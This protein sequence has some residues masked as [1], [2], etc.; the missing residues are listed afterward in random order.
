[1]PDAGPRDRRADQRQSSDSALAR[2]PRTASRVPRAAGGVQRRS[3]GTVP[4]LPERHL[5]RLRR[6][7]R[8][9]GARA[10]TSGVPPTSSPFRRSWRG[11]TC[12]S[13]TRSSTRRSTRRAATCRAPVTTSR[14]TR[15]SD[16][17]HG[18]LVRGARVLATLAPVRR[19]DR[20]VP[21]IAA[22]RRRRRLRARVLHSDVD[23]GP[24]VPLPRQLQHGGRPVRSSA[25]EPLRRA[26]RVRHL[27]RRRG[28]AR[29]RVHR[30][31]ASTSTTRS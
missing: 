22:S 6:P 7:R 3:H 30:R 11:A 15:S 13:R 12:P 20:R 2:R 1:M 10:A 31:Q 17:A 25:L 5:R 4:R 23:T 19:R 8:R 18:I 26:G 9:V 21:G 29:S 14:C 28:A 24:E 16:T 27:R